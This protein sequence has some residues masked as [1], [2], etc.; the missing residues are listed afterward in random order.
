L[1]SVGRNE[2]AG[3]AGARLFETGSV[4]WTDAAGKIVE[5]R[6]LALVGLPDVRD[7]RGV[8][9]ELLAQLDA[10][11]PIAVHPDARAGFAGGACGRVEWGG[12]SVGYVGRISRA[13]AEKLSL[14]EAPAA[15]E[16]DLPALVSGAQHVPQLTPLPRYP[17]VRRDLSL[18]L[19]EGTRYEK[20]DALIRGLK[21]T[22]LEDLEY[23]TTYRG[24]PLEKGFK[25]VTVTLIFRSPDGTLTSE[26][27]EGPVARVVEA[28]RQQLAATLRA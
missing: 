26:Q 16:L 5:Q 18:V 12:Q 9:E 28:A 23:V 17:A 15:A 3:N 6:R 21:L 13:V 11:K 1:E 22:D 2:N 8:V 27:A 24:K 19:P 25:S 7:V 4:F 14:R 20:L 10:A